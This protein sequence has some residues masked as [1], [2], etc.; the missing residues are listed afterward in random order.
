M[1][2]L[3]AGLKGVTTL[4][5]GSSTGAP[6]SGV[7]AATWRNIRRSTG[8]VYNRAECRVKWSFTSN[9]F[10]F[11]PYW[12]ILVPNTHVFTKRGFF[13]LQKG[14]LQMRN[15]AILGAVM[16]L[17]SV[18]MY[19]QEV[20]AGITGRVTDPSGSAIVGANVSAKDVDRGTDWPTTTNDDGIYAFPRIPIGRYELRV[21]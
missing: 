11:V 1:P 5:L 3:G 10:K 4:Y 21:E 17:G 19:A 14:V 7:A 6:I 13:E 8:R 12:D 2:G 18:S 16:L 20:S 9:P 15:L